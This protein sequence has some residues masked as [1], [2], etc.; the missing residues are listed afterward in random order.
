MAENIRTYLH[1]FFVNSLKKTNHKILIIFT[2]TIVKMDQKIMVVQ[3]R[4][5]LL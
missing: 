3:F 2:F 5:F 4:M 1:L